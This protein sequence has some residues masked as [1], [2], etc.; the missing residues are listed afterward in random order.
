MLSILG[1]L[2][3]LG[4]LVVVHEF[5]HFL[6]A[7]LFNVRAEAFSVGFGPRLWSKQIGETEWRLSAIPLGGYVKLFGE[8]PGVEIS[9]EEKKRALQNADA[10]KRFFIFFGGPL[11]NFLFAIV[12]FMA[13]LA[14]GE[15]Q[16][17]SSV[18]RVLPGS[19]AEQVGFQSGDRI[20]SING[21]PMKLFSDVLMKIHEHPSDPLTFVILRNGKVIDL[22]VRAQ[23][24]DGYSI[25]GEE[26]PVGRIDGLLPVARSTVVGISDPASLAAKAG[27]QTRDTISHVNGEPVSTWLELDRKIQAAPAGQPIELKL[28]SKGQTKVVRFPRGSEAKFAFENA[29]GLH[30]SELFIH[31]V[32]PDSPAKEAKLQVGDRMVAVNGQSVS[33]F[34]GLK[35]QI[36]AFGEK[37]GKIELRFERDGQTQTAVMTPTETKERDPNLRTLKQ[38]TIGVVPLLRNAQADTVV[39]RIWNPF[40]LLYEGTARMLDVSWRNV[41]AIGKMITGDVSVKTLGGPILIGKIAG[42]KLAR[43]LIE[44]LTTMA[45]LSVGLG[46][47]NILPIP[48]LDGGHLVLLGL[49][50]IRGKPL[51]IRQME[52]V[53]QVGLSLILILMAVVMRNDLARLPIFN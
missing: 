49:E 11:F 44:F 32:V 4:P 5:G 16:F 33:S 12:I 45:I 26:Q 9:P 15:P 23:A 48:V 42:E 35:D 39:E 38:Y 7:K 25:Y 14:I 2:V 50:V 40:T 43:G 36:Q 20:Q 47:L 27:I 19:Y 21:Q 22:Q 1:F 10:W 53:Q 31:E 3:I 52:I 28:T 37:E 13:I 6:F 8:E 30:S 18:G 29:W 46:V 41:V 17:S 34:F 51:S 24:E